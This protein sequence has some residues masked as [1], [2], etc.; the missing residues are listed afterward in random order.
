MSQG[1]IFMNIHEN[2]NAE[3]SEHDGTPHG[4]AWGHNNQHPLSN[5]WCILST[6]DETAISPGTG[7]NVSVKIIRKLT[8]QDSLR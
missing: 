2:P 8:W 7:D 4:S 5:I 6:D 3:Q 1:G